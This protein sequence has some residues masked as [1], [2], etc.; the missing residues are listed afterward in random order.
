MGML[1]PVLPDPE[2]L[3]DEPEVDVDVP[4]HAAPLSLSLFQDLAYCRRVRPCCK[5]MQEQN[6]AL[7]CKSPLPLPAPS[8]DPER[9]TSPTCM[10]V[11]NAT[12]AVHAKAFQVHL[13]AGLITCQTRS[14]YCNLRLVSMAEILYGPAL[15]FRLGMEM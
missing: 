12:N 8:I 4:A 5:S 3:P 13:Q 14:V 7:T 6:S 10:Q 11:A 2:E 1:G 15:L 9:L